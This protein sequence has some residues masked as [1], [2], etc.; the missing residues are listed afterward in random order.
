MV[1]F[2]LRDSVMAIGEKQFG[3][4]RIYS[5]AVSLDM[6]SSEEERKEV[7]NTIQNDPEVEDYM[8]ALES[9]VDVG[10]GNVERSSYMV[11]ASDYWKNSKTL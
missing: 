10:H 1:G 6:D 3:D 2:G 11:V 4:I 7:R 8:E 5:G 9:S